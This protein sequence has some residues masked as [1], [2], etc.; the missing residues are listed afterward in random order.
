MAA[1]A[2]TARVDP[3]GIPLAEG[4][5]TTYAFERDPDVSLWEISTKPPGLDNGEGIDQTT[6]HNDTYRVT[7]PRLLVTLSPIT[8]KFAYDP[9]VYTQI[10]ALVG[11]EGSITQHFPDGST[12]DFWGYLK[13]AEFD[14]LTRGTRPEGTATIVPTNW[15]PNNNVEA[16]PVLTSVAG[17]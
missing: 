14:E 7:R 2:T 16:G 13:S 12:L 4:A 5:S 15:D 9:A 11:Q 1:P 6:Q 8:F 10:L 3:V 17:T